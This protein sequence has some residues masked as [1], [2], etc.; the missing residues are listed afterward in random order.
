MRV[1]YVTTPLTALVLAAAAGATTGQDLSSTASLTASQQALWTHARQA[2]RQQR[3][4]AAHGRLVRLADAGH[5][6]SAQL[7]LVMY[8][9]GA[10]L[11]GSN[12]FASTDQLRRWSQLA[13]SE[14]GRIDAS[15]FAQ[16][17]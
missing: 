14:A 7:A 16:S 4:S 15:D 8:R 9:N 6:P 2:F 10:T 5:A 13:A 11:F 1:N 17:D 3:Y 12:W